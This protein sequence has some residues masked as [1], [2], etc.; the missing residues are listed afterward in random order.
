MQRLFCLALGILMVL[1]LCACSSE[2]SPAWPSVASP[3]PTAFSGESTTAATEYITVP[4]TLTTQPEPVQ[5]EPPPP[6][7]SALYLPQVSQ[8]EMIRYFN[9]VVLS[10]EYSTGSGDPTLVQKWT[11]PIQ[12][13]ISGDA[14]QEDLVVLR[15]LFDAL[16]EIEGFPGIYEATELSPANLTI[17]F[18]DSDALQLAFSDILHG[19]IADG[20][21]QFWYHTDTNEIYSGRIGYRTDIDQSLRN[22]VLLE[23]IVNLLGL[24]DT[25]LREDS[26][27]YQYGS[28]ITALSDVDWVILKL[29]YAQ[30]IL[31]GFSESQCRPILE[32]L[33]YEKENRK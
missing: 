22:S 28:N 19:E 11:C 33:Y 3:S 25:I 29:L 5:T 2:S 7:H 6:E 31:P 21:V 15:S 24:N 32:Q 27:V 14:T 13:T 16:N 23:E 30:E 17:H 4:E 12:Y 1:G 10:I 9:E 8:E 20:A 18:M 26:I